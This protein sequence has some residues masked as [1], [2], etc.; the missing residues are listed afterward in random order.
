MKTLILTTLLFS[1]TDSTTRTNF[2]T[3]H[4]DGTAIPQERLIKYE[5]KLKNL[6]KANKKVQ[7]L[8]F[9]LNH[10]KIQ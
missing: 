4:V 8:R 7:R 1:G 9:I 2:I 3:Y 10:I 6:E 5:I